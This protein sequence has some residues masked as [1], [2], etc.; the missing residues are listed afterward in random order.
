MKSIAGHVGQESR[1]GFVLR[2]HSDAPQRRR[3]SLS[4]RTL[5]MKQSILSGLRIKKQKST[6]DIHTRVN[7]ATTGETPRK[8]HDRSIPTNSIM[9]HLSMSLLLY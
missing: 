9:S 6:S 8:L 7:A 1:G 3:R 4:E 5:H 2:A